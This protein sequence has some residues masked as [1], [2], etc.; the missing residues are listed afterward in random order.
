MTVTGFAAALTLLLGFAVWAAHNVDEE[1]RRTETAFVVSG[2]NTILDR[3]ATEQESITIWDDAVVKTRQRDQVW[4]TENIGQWVGDYFGH[5]EVYVLDQHNVPIHAM[6]DGETVSPELFNKRAASI[7]PLAQQLRD[8]IASS[9]DTAIG[10]L[11]AADTVM[12]GE[13]VARVS[14]KPIVPFGTA[15]VV[16][17]GQ[18]Y[19]HVSLRRVDGDV[20]EEIERT[21]RISG[22]QSSAERPATGPLVPVANTNG[23]ILSFLTWTPNR[24]GANL[25]AQAIPGTVAAG[26]L[27]GALLAFLLMRLRRSATNLLASEAHTRFL[28]FHDTLT[29]LPNRALLDDRLDRSLA[30]A[31]E[32]GG[33]VALHLLDVDRFKL[34]NDTLGHATGDAVIRLV[35]LRLAG[36]MKST[37]TVARL[38]GDEFA[39]VQTGVSTITDAEAAARR[40]LDL[41]K[42]PLEVEGA[43]LTL[44]GS[45]GVVVTLAAENSREEMLRKA[46]IALYEAKARGRA[47]YAIFDGDMD[48]VV[49]RRRMI[50]DELGLALEVGSQVKLVY[51][52]VFAAD[53][54]WIVGAEALVRWDHPTHGRM[55]PDLFIGIAE[56][57]GLIGR[58]GDYVLREAAEFA[59]RTELPWVA[60]NVSPLQFRDPK[61]AES[62]LDTLEEVGLPPR[63]L[64]LE[65]TEG[66]LLENAVLVETALRRLRAAGIRIAL[67]DF[68]T[69]YSSMN[70]LRRYSIDKLKIDQ[71]FIAELGTSADAD[72]LVRSMIGLARSLRLVVTAEGVETTDQ[73]HHLASLGCHEMQ[74]FLLSEPIPG[75]RLL[76]L[77]RQP[78]VTKELLLS[79]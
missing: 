32:T 63:R 39:I 34:I 74:G 60:V 47:C 70:Y 77:I 23:R 31:R 43:R 18:E 44:T 46:D 6:L 75:E 64:Q 69:G 10:E 33:S 27:G 49:K 58:L 57:R 66:V 37:D 21:F 67:D 59:R 20:L 26:G 36:A 13:T 12:F 54:K 78:D 41:F 2:L 72:A 73:L 5:D 76:D 61:F 28:A 11:G 4:M 51:Q 8:D 25:I 42:D 45:I 71:S 24:P 56:E 35:G 48:D 55:S 16:D 29:G 52:P 40:L 30:G 15:M 19:L 62:V 1:A 68:G 38:G 9:Q 50:E 14:V 7:L 17:R 65:I 79:A 3:V 53:G 22:L